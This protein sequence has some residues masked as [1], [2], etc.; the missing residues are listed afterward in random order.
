MKAV[1]LFILFVVQITAPLLFAQSTATLAPDAINQHRLLLNNPVL[2]SPANA[3]PLGRNWFRLETD[4]H[5]FTDQADLRQ[6]VGVLLDLENQDKIYDGKKSKLTA[7][8]VSRSEVETIVDFVS[9]SIGP[10][11]IQYRTP[12]RS[13]VRHKCTDTKISVEFMQL[14]SDSS[15]N[16]D[17]RNF[18]S[19]QYAEEIIVEGRRYTYI[20]I[21]TISDVNAYILPGARRILEREASPVCIEGMQLIIYAAINY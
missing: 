4:I 2:V 1:F 18:Y 7:S 13:S 9:I 3:T 6:I 11:G 21:Y 20:R 19:T 8:I 12:Y 16:R 17:M 10:F 15:S 5:V 14:T